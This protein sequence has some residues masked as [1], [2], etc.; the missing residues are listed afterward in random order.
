MPTPPITLIET[1]IFIKKM[2]NANIYLILRD[3]F[4]QNAKDLGLIKNPLIFNY[5]RRKEK[6]MYKMDSLFSKISINKKIGYYYMYFRKHKTRFVKISTQDHNGVS[7]DYFRLDHLQAFDLPFPAMS[8]ILFVGSRKKYKKFDLAIDVVKTLSL[9]LVIVGG[10]NLSRNEF[11]LLESKL[12]TAHYKYVGRINNNALNIL[13]NHAFCLLY[14]SVYEGFGIPIIEAQ[15]AGCP[16][17]AFD[18]SSIKDIIGNTPL[19][20]QKHTVEDI[21]KC[22]SILYKESTQNCIIN[23]GLKNSSRFS[24]DITYH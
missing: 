24:W 22:V 12:G 4:P 20:F 11:N 17:I 18:G 6:K 3:I 1:A 7:D 13:Y 15:K 19:L 8:Y 10:E 23:E 9:N 21:T 2:Y 16:V 14:P 5:F